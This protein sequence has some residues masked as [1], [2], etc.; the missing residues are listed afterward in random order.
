M[1]GRGAVTCCSVPV[2]SRS[3]TRSELAVRI[4]EGFLV[5]KM[6]GESKPCSG[7]CVGGR[8]G[9]GGKDVWSG[10]KKRKQEKRKGGGGGKR[11]LLYR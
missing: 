5:R 4:K 9:R 1:K 10:K 2:G 8:S 7:D 6:T 11:Q 3:S